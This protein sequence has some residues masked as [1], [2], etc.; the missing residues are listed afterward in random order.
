V[1]LTRRQSDA[2]RFIAR[3]AREHGYSPTVREVQEGIGH[4]SV[5]STHAVLISLRDL[6]A[7]EWNRDR[8]RTLRVK[9]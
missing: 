7:I 4:R 1:D 5:S 9:T 8:P 2:L 3:F 6:E